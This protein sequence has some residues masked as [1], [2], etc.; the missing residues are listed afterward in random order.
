MNLQTTIDLDIKGFF[1]W[2]SRELAFLVPQK[3]TQLWSDRYGKLVFTVTDQGFNVDFYRDAETV[4]VFSRTLD[5]NDRAA[6][7]NLINEYADSKKADRILRLTDNQAIKKLLFLPAAAQEN[8]KQV[9]GFELDRYTPFKPEQVYFSAVPLE[10][11]EHGQLQVM[12]V[13]TQR[14]F[15]DKRLSQLGA[16]FVRPSRVEFQ[17]LNEAYPQLEGQYN[18]LPESYR[19]GVNKLAQSIHWLLSGVMLMLLLSVLVFPVWHEKQAV[20]ILKNQIKALEKETRI[21]DDQQLKIDALRDETQ[22][23]IDIKYQTPDMV[24]VL[25]ELSRLLKDDTWLTHLQY[26]ETHMQIQGQSPASSALISLLEASPFFSNV[27]FASP[28]T[29][30]KTTGLERFQISMDVGAIAPPAAHSDTVEEPV[31]T[32]EAVDAAPE[33]E[34]SPQESETN[35]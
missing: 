31:V 32:D 20:D 16:W 30:D 33:E 11:T 10:V 17:P 1:R 3:L 29:Q 24:A 23:L 7:Q 21:V 6:Y 35:E 4:P 15:L 14:V 18:L 13:L 5:S 19:P 28:L 2:W 26:S 27:S 12:L 25:N 22:R 9:V 34:A 8:L